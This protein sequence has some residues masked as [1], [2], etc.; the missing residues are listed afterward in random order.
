VLPE[1]AHL[2]RLNAAMKGPTHP[3]TTQQTRVQTPRVANSTPLF[4]RNSTPRHM[5][6]ADLRANTAIHSQDQKVDTKHAPSET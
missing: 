2:T 3:L 4:D 5:L 1:L 6:E